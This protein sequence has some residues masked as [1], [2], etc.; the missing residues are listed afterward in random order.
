MAKTIERI[1]LGFVEGVEEG[2]GRR[3]ESFY[4]VL[5]SF[6]VLGRFLG[7]SSVLGRYGKD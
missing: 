7:A 6:R 5:W 4:G 3:V 2:D 1:K